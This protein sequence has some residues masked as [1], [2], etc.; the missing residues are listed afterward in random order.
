[1]NLAWVQRCGSPA[2]PRS[3]PPGISSMQQQRA[4]FGRRHAAFALKGRMENH[5]YL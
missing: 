4:E 1:M 2:R 3:G 5:F